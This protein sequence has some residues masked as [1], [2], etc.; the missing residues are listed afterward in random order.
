MANLRDPHTPTRSAR[1]PSIVRRHLPSAALDAP[2]NALSEGDV[3]PGPCNAVLATYQRLE[4]AR[5]TPL[6]P[7]ADHPPYG[8]PPPLRDRR[9]GRPAFGLYAVCRP[10]FERHLERAGGCP[11][12]SSPCICF[13]P[14][15]RN[16]NALKDLPSRL[17]CFWA[18]PVCSL[19]PL[20]VSQF[21]S[22][23]FHPHGR[24][25]LLGSFRRHAASRPR[26]SD[27]LHFVRGLA[28]RTVSPRSDVVRPV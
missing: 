7:C 4:S 23:R 1:T 18:P 5:P 21:A 14:Q 9:Q 26:R 17:N 13:S 11:P 28:V 6:D 15:S 3:W 24:Q 8:L 20:R 27:A 10:P 12:L 25:F 22:I 19:S 16:L 2:R